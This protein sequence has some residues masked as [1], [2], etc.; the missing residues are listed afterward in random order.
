VPLQNITVEFPPGGRRVFREHAHTEARNGYELVIL[1]VPD[2]ADSEVRPPAFLVAD[3]MSHR[4][5]WSKA[6]KARAEIIR[7]TFLR[8]GFTGTVGA[9][10]SGSASATTKP[11]KPTTRDNH[12]EDVSASVDAT[13]AATISKMPGI[14]KDPVHRR[15]SIT[16][17]KREMYQS[18]QQTAME[19]SEDVE[20]AGAV[21]EFGFA[22]FN[23]VDW[24]N[25]FFQVH[26]DFDAPSKCRQLE[27]WQ[28][29]MKKS[30]KG[31]VLEQ[32]EY[33]V[34]ASGEM[35]TMGR[36][37]SSLKS[38]I[39]TQVDTIREMKEIDFSGALKHIFDESPE[40]EGSDNAFGLVDQ[41]QRRD[42]DSSKDRDDRSIFSEV[43]SIG[44]SSRRGLSAV[45]DVDE[46]T[47]VAPPI[48]VP[49]WLDDVT[50]D[51]SSLI[52]ANRY[53]EAVELQVKAR[54]EVTDLVEKHERPTAYKLTKKQLVELKTLQEALEKLGNR[55]SARL[56]ETLRRK[57]EA[58]RQ[59]SKRERTDP[60]VSITSSVSPCAL[61]DDAT[62]LHLLVKIGKTSIAADAYS[63]RR[64]LLLQ[65]ALNE[66]PI[67]GAGSV[68]LVIYAA[69]ISQSFFSCLAN[70][71][72]GF[73]DLFLMSPANG[74]KQEDDSLASSSL[75]SQTCKN[76]PAGA[77][78]SVV[79]WCDTELSKFASAFGGTRVL[80]NLSL[81]PPP[82]DGPKKPRVV[83]ET[84]VEGSKER[85]NAID[86]AAQCLDQ[87][88]LYASQNL[89]TVGL[90]LTP[91][92]A[93]LLRPRLKGCEEE[94]SLLLDERWKNLTA[95]WRTNGS[96]RN[97]HTIPMNGNGHANG[98]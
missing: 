81:S 5:K 70:A 23:E 29:E 55:I 40:E 35:T 87:A 43:S 13:A 54:A 67:S 20:L 47:E 59:A 22:A 76:I 21:V 10:G 3:S 12:K 75:H 51:I 18:L 46:S 83:G 25:N 66:R 24:M 71:V 85:R 95:D 58:L 62:Y 60:L 78:A 93:E 77:V 91:R 98:R 94:V 30:L 11:T 88:F 97:G 36:E 15:K 4:E 49:E 63:S 64:S 16:T 42:A 19:S 39:E 32:Y 57:N 92:M 38:L 79:L 52:R 44:E 53:S 72:E 61:N 48:N 69:Q 9:S 45:E 31:A 80:A 65:E 34:Q 27:H 2:D 56:E 89:D 17:K 73:L 90:P 74:D 82:R 33:F 37:V 1:H 7:P 50:E 96:S 14:D 8:G 86:V 84:A 68:D 28:V 6:L 41:Q 26:N